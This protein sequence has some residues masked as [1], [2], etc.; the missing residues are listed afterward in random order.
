MFWINIWLKS[1]RSGHFGPELDVNGAHTCVSQKIT[2]ENFVSS[3]IV[4]SKGILLFFFRSLSHIWRIA[5]PPHRVTFSCRSL[6]S[7]LANLKCFSFSFATGRTQLLAAPVFGEIT[8]SVF[9]REKKLQQ[10]HTL[11]FLHQYEV[12][13][14][15][16]LKQQP[17]CHCIAVGQ[18][19]LHSCK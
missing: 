12:Q 8:F 17:D 3:P 9:E 5:F 13:S 2:N 4:P 14:H 18:T 10:F 6:S 19:M 1:S 7:P 16:I 11:P 15:H